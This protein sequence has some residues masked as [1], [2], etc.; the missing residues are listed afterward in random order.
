MAVQERGPDVIAAP[1]PRIRD[2]AIPGSLILAGLLAV[3]AALRLHQLGRESVWLD[4]AFSIA[5]AND[6]LTYLV[7]MTA[8]DVHPPLYY[9][10][11]HYWIDLMGATEWAARLL[12]VA[13]SLGLIAAGGL[14]GTRMFDRQ[15]GLLAAGL[16]TLARFQVEFAQEARMYALLALLATVSTYCL[17][18]LYSRL[19]PDAGAAGPAGGRPSATRWLVAYVIATALMTYTQVHSAFVVAAHGAIVGLDLVRRG[20][21]ALPFTTRW[22]V[23]LVAIVL[24]FT[25]WLAIFVSQVSHVQRGFWIPEPRWY[26]LGSAFHTYAG[27]S[28]LT[29]VL[30]PLCGLGLWR[31]WRGRPGEAAPGSG[32]FL[33]AWL[34]CPIALPLALSVVGSPIYLPKYTIAA[35]VPFMLLAAA[36]L[37]ALPGRVRGVAAVV[38]VALAA[39][40]LAAFYQGP[41]RKDDWRGTV[42][43]VEARARPGDTVLFYPF[44]T[45]IPYDFYQSRPDVI[46]APFPRMAEVATDPAVLGMLDELI[47]G[48]D[49]VW[50]VAMSFD[51]RKPAI[52]G[53]LAERF[54]RIERTQAFH[55]DAYLFSKPVRPGPTASRKGAPDPP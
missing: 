9:L 34:V 24:C 1:E 5:I 37:R 13:F 2:E 7:Q 3:G 25:P 23:A 31:A 49:R 53:A 4:E 44:F 11:L 48:K 6:T 16:L 29:T 17:F 19:T 20:R 46:R 51:E 35:S 27:S 54:A 21:R 30:V 14:V 38:L 43:E 47:A 52:V 15:T 40:A 18:R 50:L 8:Q 33:T 39:Q 26:D 55:V 36:G 45:K 32:L 42:R 12:S 10:L 22:M 41:V 28:R